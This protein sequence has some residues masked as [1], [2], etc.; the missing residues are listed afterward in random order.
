MTAMKVPVRT[1]R[2]RVDLQQDPQGARA[3]ERGQGRAQLGLDQVAGRPH[4][5]GVGGP[6]GAV[7]DPLRE[8]VQLGRQARAQVDIRPAG[9]K[10][11]LY[12]T[13]GGSCRSFGVLDEMRA[14][15]AAPARAP[16]ARIVAASL[17]RKSVV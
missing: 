2:H 1:P 3:R 10:D 16:T 15:G 5:G 6:G 9:R 7:H 4:L 8:P 12:L 11:E 13:H 17:D 14:V